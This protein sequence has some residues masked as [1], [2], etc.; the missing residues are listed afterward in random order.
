MGIL[1]LFSSLGRLKTNPIAGRWPNIRSPKSEIGCRRTEVRSP[2]PEDRNLTSDTRLPSSGHR[3]RAGKLL[4]NKG[5]IANLGKKRL[6][7]SGGSDTIYNIRGFLWKAYMNVFKPDC[8]L[9]GGK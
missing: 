9:V 7:L 2:K 1:V 3:C 5:I 6:H 4:I 8:R